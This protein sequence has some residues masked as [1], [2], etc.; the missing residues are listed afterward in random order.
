MIIRKLGPR[1]DLA[2]ATGLLQRFFAE[3][4]FSTPADTI[5]TRVHM[6]ASLDT[7]ALLVAEKH[8]QAFG[9]ATISSEFGKEFGWWA[10]MGDLYVIPELRGKGIARALVTAIEDWLRQRGIAGYQVTVTPRGDD[11]HGLM[12]YYRQLG[13]STEG[14]LLLFKDV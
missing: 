2:A 14:R 10:E 9:V 4:S 1:D 13:F 7:C 6:L 11:Q 8:G 5:A 3:E 12:A